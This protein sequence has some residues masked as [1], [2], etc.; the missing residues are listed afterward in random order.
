MLRGL[1]GNVRAVILVQQRKLFFKIRAEQGRAGDGGAVAA[2]VGKTGVGAG[3]WRR[4]GA[5][6][7]GHRERWINKKALVSGLLVGKFPCFD[8]FA[9]GAAQRIDGLFI[10]RVEFFQRLSRGQAGA[11]IIHL[12]LLVPQVCDSTR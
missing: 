12:C 9:D 11:L 10:Q 5:A 4:A 8:I 6:V 3:F 2:G 1:N 7:P